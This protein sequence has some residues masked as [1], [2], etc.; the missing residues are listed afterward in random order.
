MRRRRPRFQTL[1]ARRLLAA[2]EIPD[3]LTAAPAA[4]V[5]VPVNIDDAAGVRGA[6]IRLEFDPELLSLDASDVTAGSVWDGAS[7]AQVTVNIDDATGM[8]VIFVSASAALSTGSGSLVEL[9]FTVSDTATVGETSDLDLITAV[10][11]EG[12]V[13]VS[14][15][16]VAG[17]DQTDG[18]LTIT[19]GGTD[20]ISGAVYADANGNGQMDAGEAIGG[21]TITLT[22]D[23]TDEQFQTVTDTD[24]SYEFTELTPGDYT[25]TE[26]QPVAFIDGG[27]NE[28]SV[29][30]TAGTPADDQDFV[31]DGLLP[32]Y[33]YTRLLTTLVMPV[34]STSWSNEVT[35]ITTD[36]ETGTAPTA[37]SVPSSSSASSVA[38]V[39]AESVVMAATQSMIA[40]SFGS[41]PESEDAGVG[42]RAMLSAEAESP[43]AHSEATGDAKLAAG[44]QAVAD[45]IIVCTN[46]D[47]A[48]QAE[49]ASNDP[50]GAINQDDDDRDEVVDR[51]LA[52][53]LW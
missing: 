32:Q 41:E 39:S 43:E 35:R 42:L 47:L 29:T 19:T 12:Q 36:A 6:E 34:G 40:S 22:N 45:P 23:S 49:P 3:D 30:L 8:V 51:V 50:Q 31:E 38:A 5:S 28:L 20:V 46:D 33:L 10:L 25:I 52:S 4:V 16:P 9:E 37:P 24:G 17:S 11:N 2:V 7:D 1:T 18:V 21:V 44:L 13:N 27:N 53:D 26:S 48:V 14:P 15:A